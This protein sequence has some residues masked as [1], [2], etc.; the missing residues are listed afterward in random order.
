MP[1]LCFHV[2]ELIDHHLKALAGYGG[3][4]TFFTNMRSRD[5]LEIITLDSV[6]SLLTLSL[7]VIIQNVMS[8]IQF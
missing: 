4:N 1:D 7:L 6:F 2:A 5:R 3:R 8:E